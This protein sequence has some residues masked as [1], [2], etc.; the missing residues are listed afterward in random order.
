M[1]CQDAQFQKLN[2][3]PTNEDSQADPQAIRDQLSFAKDG[4]KDYLKVPDMTDQTRA[5]TGG[6]KGANT[7]IDQEVMDRVSGADDGVAE[8][9]APA[10]GMN[11]ADEVDDILG[12]L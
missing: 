8:E 6:K 11:V 4:L 3:S 7:E 5:M 9:A 12:D 1:S 2:F 10:A